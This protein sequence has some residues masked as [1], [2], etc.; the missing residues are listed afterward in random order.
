MPKHLHQRRAGL[1]KDIVHPLQLGVEL[2]LR[3][4]GGAAVGGSVVAARD[5]TNGASSVGNAAVCTVHRFWHQ[6]LKPFLPY[7]QEVVSLG[8]CQQDQWPKNNKGQ[9]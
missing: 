5:V 7:G 3:G 4:G 8:G 2:L 6:Q 9:R 1:V